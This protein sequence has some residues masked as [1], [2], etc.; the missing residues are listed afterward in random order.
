MSQYCDEIS[1]DLNKQVKKSLRASEEEYVEI[2]MNAVEGALKQALTDKQIRLEQ[3]E[4]QL[5]SSEEDRNMSFE[6]WVAG[7][8]RIW[9]TIIEE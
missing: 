6:D 7:T 8:D 9:C 2:V 4:K 5:Q 3:L 1:D